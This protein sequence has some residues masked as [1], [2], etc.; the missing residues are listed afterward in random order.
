MIPVAGLARGVT[1][2]GAD[3]SR[4]AQALSPWA[5]AAPSP[6]LHVR[7][8]PSSTLDVAFSYTHIPA[9][10]FTFAGPAERSP[11][12]VLHL[13]V[14]DN[15]YYQRGIPGVTRSVE[16]T[17]AWLA[18]VRRAAGASRTRMI[19]ASMGAYAA[20]LFGDLI[21]ADAIYAFSPVLKPG[22]LALGQRTRFRDI[23]SRLPAL[24]SR[25][26]AT[27][28]AFELGEYQFALPCLEAGM[29][30][31]DLHFFANFHPGL[32][33][34]RLPALFASPKVLAA[35]AILVHPHR[36]GLDAQDV[37]LLAGLMDVIAR[38]DHA[39]AASV[40][41]PLSRRDAANAGLLYRLGVHQ[42]LAGWPAAARVSLRGACALLDEIGREV[43]GDDVDLK[44]RSVRD[45]AHLLGFG[46]LRDI[47]A[48]LD[49]VGRPAKEGGM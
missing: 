8:G 1:E 39:G 44:K 22:H 45:Y 9:G 30:M 7:P 16:E 6:Y 24:A 34:I 37:G 14:R 23:S 47:H 18:A 41:G 46:P 13:N 27:F 19:G 28:G 29:T 32:L 31:A 5:D 12:T 35:D 42:A 40:L 4:M 48:L 49:E 2:A 43:L 26:I 17:A 11:N 21:D 3:A 20:L 10:Q 33:S 25:A 38:R 15:D 36:S